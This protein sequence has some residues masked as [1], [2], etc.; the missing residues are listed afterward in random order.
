MAASV[1]VEAVNIEAGTFVTSILTRVLEAE[2]TTSTF[3]VGDG[4]TPAGW[5]AAINMETVG[6]YIPVTGTDAYMTANG[7]YY[8]TADTIDIT[9]SAHAVDTGIVEIIVFC[10]QVV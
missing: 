2:D 1:V 5:D 9:L 10:F 8:S 4:V 6:N 7:K 3:S